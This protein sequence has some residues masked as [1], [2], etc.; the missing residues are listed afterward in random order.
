MATKK[1]DAG[2]T[3]S[4]RR[5]IK[6][7]PTS[8]MRYLLLLVVIVVV[9]VAGVVVIG[10]SKKQPP[11]SKSLSGE[12]ARTGAKRSSRSDGGSLAKR[13]KRRDREQRLRERQLRRERR[14]QLA[15]GKRGGRSRSSSYR[16]GGAGHRL[17]MIVAEGSQQ[18]AVIDNRRLKVGDQ[19]GGRKINDIKSDGMTVEYLGKTYPVKIGQTVY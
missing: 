3:R 4:P 7:K 18:F 15:R 17:Q 9:V 5:G 13:D 8:M 11:K 16:L 2:P 6:K 12:T 19:V 1:T 10:G 14:R